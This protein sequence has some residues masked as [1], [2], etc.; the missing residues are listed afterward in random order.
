[1]LYFLQVLS[2]ETNFCS[3]LKIWPVRFPRVVLST[4]SSLPLPKGKCFARK[5]FL[6]ERKKFEHSMCAKI[7]KK[8]EHFTPFIGTIYVWTFSV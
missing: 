6:F 4:R 8:I 5:I 7:F 3:V 1:M 2:L